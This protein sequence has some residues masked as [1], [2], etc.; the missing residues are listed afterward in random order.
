MITSATRKSLLASGLALAMAATRSALA[1]DPVATPTAP[2]PGQPHGTMN[3]PFAQLDANADGRISP[4]EALDDAG[5]ML[6]FKA[7][8]VDQDGAVSLEEY[9]GLGH[10]LWH[11]RDVNVSAA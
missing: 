3:P 1:A 11:P 2:A 6:R 7:M 9:S 10:A 4:G 8:D 5:V